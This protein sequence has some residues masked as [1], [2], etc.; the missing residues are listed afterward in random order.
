MASSETLRPSAPFHTFQPR[1]QRLVCTVLV[2]NYGSLHAKQSCPKMEWLKQSKTSKTLY[3]PVQPLL[4]WS[5]GSSISNRSLRPAANHS[6][7]PAAETPCCDGVVSAWW[8]LGCKSFVSQISAA[9]YHCIILIHM[10]YEII[11]KIGPLKTVVFHR[12]APGSTWW[13]LELSHLS[14]L[15]R[16]G[17]SAFRRGLHGIHGDEISKLVLW[18]TC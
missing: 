8:K 9:L 10:T 14:H 17:L 16:L 1:H 4:V 3:N 7:H 18:M 2:Q 15:G 12:P 5:V 11:W 13:G 6:T